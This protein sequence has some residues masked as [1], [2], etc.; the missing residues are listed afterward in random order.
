MFLCISP[1]PFALRRTKGKEQHRLALS[2][3]TGI[4]VVQ[5]AQNVRCIPSI[6]ESLRDCFR[7]QNQP[8]EEVPARNPGRTRRA[9]IIDRAKR[10]TVHLPSGLRLGRRAISPSSIRQP[11]PVSSPCLLLPQLSFGEASFGEALLDV[12]ELFSSVSGSSNPTSLPSNPTDQSLLPS[13]QPDQSSDLRGHSLKPL[14]SDQTGRSLETQDQPIQADEHGAECV[15]QHPLEHT[16]TEGSSPDFLDHILQPAPHRAQDTALLQTCIGAM[17]AESERRP[18]RERRMRVFS[19]GTQP[20]PLITAG[21]HGGYSLFPS[22]RQRTGIAAIH[23]A[24]RP[25]PEPEQ[26]EQPDQPD[27]PDQPEQTKA[28]ARLD[29]A[30]LPASAIHRVST[31]DP[32]GEELRDSGAD[33]DQQHAPVAG[34]SD[35]SNAKTSPLVRTESQ[36]ES[37]VED[38]DP[39]VLDRRASPSPPPSK[40]HSQLALTKTPL[41]SVA[42]A[43]SLRTGRPSR[44][45]P[46]SFSRPQN[47]RPSGMVA[48]ASSA[49]LRDDVSPVVGGP[50]SSSRIPAARS[51]P[52]PLPVS[53]CDLTRD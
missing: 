35:K 36:I 43:P 49:S 30:A 39:P 31:L 46:A 28:K 37:A 27:Q 42:S 4:M 53:P 3:K 45:R 25:H 5:Q 8:G 19:D 7:R 52:S 18:A 47:G 23:P 24:L 17:L 16:S 1:R 15:A 14:P 32:L 11:R 12:D 33:V 51:S 41:A 21:S 44:C 50:S 48:A 6:T 22:P 40:T 2:Y 38:V 10:A 34:P 13:H 9:G 29:S 26:P 20:A